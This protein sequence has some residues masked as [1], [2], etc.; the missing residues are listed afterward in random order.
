MCIFDERFH[1][2]S[3][4]YIVYVR[5]IAVATYWERIAHPAYDV[6]SVLVPG[7]RFGGFPPRI[8]EME[9]R[10]DCNIS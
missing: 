3:N 8:L 1:I 4:K 7:C 9:S 5:V 10:S 6:F 2:F